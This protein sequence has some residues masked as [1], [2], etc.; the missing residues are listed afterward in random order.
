MRVNSA[1][2]S[3]VVVVVALDGDALAAELLDLRGGRADGAGDRT[4]VDG[5]AGDVDGRARGTELERD[6][7]ADAPARAGDDGD[8]A[9]ECAAS[10]TSFAHDGEAT[11]RADR[12]A[13]ATSYQLPPPP[14]P[15]PP[16]ENPPPENPLD[17]PDV[18]AGTDVSVPAVA[19]VKLL[20]AAPSRT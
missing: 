15:K 8:L 20:S 3:R 16:P 6:A 11:R 13:A 9:L 12:G 19:T 2:T 1:S 4:G 18:D 5:P 17:P 10:G 14:P 7:L